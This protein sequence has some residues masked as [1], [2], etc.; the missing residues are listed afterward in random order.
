MPVNAM[1]LQQLAQGT[2]FFAN[3]IGRAR[4]VALGSGQDFI[5]VAAFK[6]ADCP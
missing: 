3:Q 1:F 5:Q 6:F 4:D 2:S